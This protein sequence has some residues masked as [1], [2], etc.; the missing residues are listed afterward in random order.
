MLNGLRAKRLCA[1]PAL[2]G[3]IEEVEDMALPLGKLASIYGDTTYPH[4][5]IR[6]WEQTI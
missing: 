2:P 4:E 3:A 1:H 5:T 6:E